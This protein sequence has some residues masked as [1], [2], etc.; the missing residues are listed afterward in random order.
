MI[1]QNAT[2]EVTVANKSLEVD[3]ENKA[4]ELKT[5]FDQNL[6]SKLESL[7]MTRKQALIRMIIMVFT[8]STTALVTYPLLIIQKGGLEIATLI[9]AILIFVMYRRYI[10]S[11]RKYSEGYKSQVIT[12]LLTSIN[13]SYDYE[14]KRSITYNQFKK[15]G[16]FRTSVDLFEGEDYVSGLLGNNAIEFSELDV[17]YKTTRHQPDGTK[18]KSYH[19]IFKGLFFVAEA[20]SPFKSETY[21]LNA[22]DSFLS[23]I[24]EKFSSGNNIHGERVILENQEFN[25]HFEVYSLDPAEAQN[26]VSPLLMQR[27]VNF[28]RQPRVSE[29][30][31]SF[32][33]GCLYIA[34][35]TRKNYFEPKLF[36]PAYSYNVVQEIYADIEFINDV[37]D[38]LRLNALTDNTPI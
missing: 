33:E 24:A 34:L 4:L 38:D 15:S 14:P 32:V 21:I 27:L 6:K 11:W 7:D 35:S 5:L 23:A 2:S 9:T 20:N 29:V 17:Q 31:L 13:D 16:L 30:N 3:L 1:N 26:L 36:T 25:H 19:T 10:V 12:N 28:K 18:T 22:R 8:V 37:A